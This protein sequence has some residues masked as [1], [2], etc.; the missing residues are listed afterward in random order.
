MGV[1]KENEEIAQNA[2]TGVVPNQGQIGTNTTMTLDIGHEK[3]TLK[4]REI[5]NPVR[6][7][8]DAIEYGIKPRLAIQRVEAETVCDVF[9]GDKHSPV[10]VVTG[11]AFYSQRERA[12]FVGEKGKKEAFKEALNRLGIHRIERGPLWN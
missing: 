12:G 2:P 6:A 1:G 9:L 4:F 5:F 7:K 8:V 3:F 10:K 11:R